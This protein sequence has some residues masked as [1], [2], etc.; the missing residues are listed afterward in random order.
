MTRRSKLDMWLDVLL[1][2]KGGRSKPTLIMYGA[3]L[4]WRPLQ[5]ILKLLMSLGLIR[6]MDT[7]VMRKND[8]RAFKRYEI[9][10]K[11]ED[12]IRCFNRVKKSPQARG[13]PERARI[14]L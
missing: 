8:R 9:T 4:S 1:V 3:N 6:E 12:S 10:R 11:G 13:S 5:E 14:A 2:I 7:Q